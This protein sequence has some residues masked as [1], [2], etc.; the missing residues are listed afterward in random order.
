M[1]WVTAVY[2]NPNPMLQRQ[3]W[4][5]IENLAPSIQEPWLIGGDFNSI[6][7]A[8]EKQG[9]VGRNSGVCNLFRKWF[10]GH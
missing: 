9:G 8:L 2:A 7:Y 10:D 3:L 4:C 6:L 1:S 5:H